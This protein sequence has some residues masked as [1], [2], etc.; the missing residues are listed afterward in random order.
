M[1]RKQKGPS[2]ADEDQT[3]TH[4]TA[5]DIFLKPVRKLKENLAKF[6]IFDPLQSGLEL[7][8]LPALSTVRQPGCAFPKNRSKV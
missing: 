6:L 3:L 2:P 1:M 8:Q 7:T 5:E 4:E